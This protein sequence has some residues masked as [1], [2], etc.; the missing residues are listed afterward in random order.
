[1]TYDNI[2]MYIFLYMYVYIYI[3][4]Y[5]LRQR[6]QVAVV[7]QAPQPPLLYVHTIIY[8]CICTDVYYVYREA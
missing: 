7:W 3:C 8:I 1:M 4:I 5:T 2:C 6:E